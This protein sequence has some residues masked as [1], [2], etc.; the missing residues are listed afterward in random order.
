MNARRK[1]APAGLLSILALLIAA[2]ASATPSVLVDRSADSLAPGDGVAAAPA[3]T[4][5]VAATVAPGVEVAAA[6][7]AP[8]GEVSA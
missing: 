3:Q 6:S 2:C 8:L 7:Q 1:L 4:L 5:V